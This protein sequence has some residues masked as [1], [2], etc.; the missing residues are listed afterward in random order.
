MYKEHIWMVYWN[1]SDIVQLQ[2]NFKHVL[3]LSFFNIKKIFFLVFR[4]SYELLVNKNAGITCV[5]VPSSSDHLKIAG[6][7]KH[8][9]KHALLRFKFPMLNTSV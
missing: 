9:S 2:D 6:E 5:K 8:P 4:F 3:Y 7:G 1:V